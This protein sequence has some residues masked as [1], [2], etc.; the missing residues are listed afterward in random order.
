MKKILLAAFVVLSVL[1][2]SSG[3]KSIL[4]VTAS[5]LS[6]STQVIVYKLNV[7]QLQTVDTLYV[8]GGHAKCGILSDRTVPDF[9]YVDVPGKCRVS[10]ILTPGQ[11]LDVNLDDCSV[12]GSEE[13]VLFNQVESEY[14]SLSQ[15]VAEWTKEYTEATDSTVK[16][17]AS[18]N[19]I[20]SFVSFKKLSIK[21][22]MT[23]PASMTNI[24]VLFRKISEIP[25][26]GDA[27]DVFLIQKVY[28]TLS[29]LYP[30]SPY[31]MSLKNEID[32][33]KHIMELND[34]I[35]GAQTVSVPD[36]QLPDVNGNRRS[37][38]GIKD[39]V[40][41]LLF[42]ESGLENISVMNAEIKELYSKYKDSGFE[43][44]QVALDVDK[45]A[46]AASVKS[47]KIEWVSVVDTRGI[48]STYIPLYSVSNLPYALVLGRDGG[49]LEKGA[50]DIEKLEKVISSALKK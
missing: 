1:S 28:D 7:S 46:W 27:N 36:I 37:L 31:V 44:F 49:V 40:I 25:V 2:C 16:K 41:L 10:L 24:P 9:Y 48:Q 4:N 42:W 39:K 33:R 8:V 18:E 50:V 45:T 15:R 43:I 30:E 22:V 3:S 5:S 35:A 12:T 38:L 14:A 21:H 17:A 26:F 34:M 29:V 47:Q 13:A 19:I 23:H 32:S 6:D 11:V 20:K